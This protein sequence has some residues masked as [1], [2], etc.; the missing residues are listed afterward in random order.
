[1]RGASSTFL[2]SSDVEWVLWHC[3]SVPHH[4][5]GYLPH[6]PVQFQVPGAGQG[7]EV[8]LDSDGGLLAPY[9]GQSLLVILRGGVFLQCPGRS[10]ITTTTVSTM[11]YSG[12]S[13]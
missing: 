2:G 3:P 8:L 1:M 11:N 9:G 10:E 4:L 7:L 6:G 12:T 5:L 13:S